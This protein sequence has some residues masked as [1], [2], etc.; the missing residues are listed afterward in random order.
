MRAKKALPRGKQSAETIAK[1]VAKLTGR[2]NTDEQKQKMSD[3]QK[4]RPAILRSDEEK[5]KISKKISEALTGKSK[6]EEHKKKLSEIFNGRSNG[7]RSEETKQKMRKPKSVAHRKA[8][9]EARIA[10]YAALR[11]NSTS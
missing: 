10:K 3:S 8:I 11:G 5:E 7:K 2:H 9:S 4:G 1:R 6:S